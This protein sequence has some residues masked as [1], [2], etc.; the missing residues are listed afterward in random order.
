MAH[1][2]LSFLTYTDFPTRHFS[3]YI[4]RDQ[5]G[6]AQVLVKREAPSFSVPIHAGNVLLHCLVIE[7]EPYTIIIVDL[8]TE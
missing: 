8:L 3:T 5:E 1:E 6:P 4:S 2:F 7:S